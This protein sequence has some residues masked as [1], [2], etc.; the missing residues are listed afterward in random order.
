[1]QLDPY[2]KAVI[3]LRIAAFCIWKLYLSRRRNVSENV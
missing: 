2:L 3:Q 1:M